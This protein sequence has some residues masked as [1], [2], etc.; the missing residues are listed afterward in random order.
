M[1][2]KIKKSLSL[3][4]LIL[5]IFS[6]TACFDLNNQPNNPIIDLPSIKKV[7]DSESCISNAWIEFDRSK[8]EDDP[9]FIEIINWLKDNNI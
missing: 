6:F 4:L 9:V 2:N 7:L 3:L 5:A 1:L 8:F